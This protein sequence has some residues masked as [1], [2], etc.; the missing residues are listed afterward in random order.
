MPDTALLEDLFYAY[1]TARQNKRNTINQ[2]KF[3][4]NFEHEIF[5]LHDE[6]KARTYRPK[7]EIAF[8]INRPVKREIFAA[9]FRDRVVH[10]LL[11]GYISPIIE[12]YLIY[13]CCSC[14]RGKGTSAGIQRAGR[15]LRACSDNHTKEC[16]IMK[17]D[18]SGYFMSINREWL[19][20]KVNGLLMKEYQKCALVEKVVSFDPDMVDFLIQRTLFRN[21]ADNCLIKGSRSNWS[22]LPVNKSLFYASE[23][24]GL[25][26]G[27]LTSQLFGNVYLNDFDHWMKKRM[28][29]HY[30]G[31][32]VDDFYVMCR[33]K[34]RLLNALP[35]IVNYLKEKEALALH[36]DKTKIKNGSDGFLFLGVVIKPYRRYISSRTKGNFYQKIQYWNDFFAGEEAD[37]KEEDRRQFLSSMNSYLG[38]MRHYHTVKLRRKMLKD[39]LS[40]RF[41]KHVHISG[42]FEK[43]EMD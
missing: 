37:L 36:P 28:G 16:C 7:R 10:H 34:E 30:Y 2:L 27:N 23:G 40:R 26:I 14:R 17:M 12:K 20:H 41:W 25:P 1:Y 21:P 31:R 9:D 4:L 24:C 43:V 18:I 11:F 3:E 35:E 15:F 5:K 38:I 8:I 32:Y 6:I 13:D 33:D 19:Y 22:G 29:F 42:N 39:H